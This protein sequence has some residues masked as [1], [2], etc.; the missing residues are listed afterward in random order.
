MTRIHQSW[1]R[2]CLFLVLGLNLAACEPA[3]TNIE[4][5]GLNYT[6]NPIGFSVNGGIG[7]D[8]SPNSGGGSFVCCVGLPK[9][10]RQGLKV[11]VRWRDDE[12]HPDVWKE[13]IVDVPRYEA[14]DI[15][16]F[17]VHFFPDNSVKVLVTTKTARY[18]GY[19]YPRPS[20]E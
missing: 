7:D 17:A 6:S 11:T 10:W 4:I 2:Y 8:I 20:K 12:Q 13:Q 5:C 15:G 3:M 18:P 14:S 1:L 16:F 19:P 9:R